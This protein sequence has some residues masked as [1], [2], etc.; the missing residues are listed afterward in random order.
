M[1]A[2]GRISDCGVERAMGKIC[3]CNGLGRVQETLRISRRR[4]RTAAFREPVVAKS[5]RKA[6]TRA[7]GDID[8][9]EKRRNE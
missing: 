4:C 6:G 3:R 1:P 5:K 2:D 7:A 9:I 8:R